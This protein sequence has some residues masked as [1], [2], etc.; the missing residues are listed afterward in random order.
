MREIDD[1]ILQPETSQQDMLGA[2]TL[3]QPMEVNTV[4]STAW[5]HYRAN[6]SRYLPIALRGTGW[7][8]FP[9][10]FLLS[11]LLYMLQQ[12]QV[13]SD[14]SGLTALIVPAW[15]VL[16]LW[17]GA[18][19]LGEFAGISR[20][21]HQSLVFQSLE[22]PEETDSEALSMTL[23]FTHSRRF[24]LLGSAIIKGAILAAINIL[25]LFVLAAAAVMVFIGLGILPGS[26]PNLGL[27]FGGGAVALVSLIV[28]GWLYTW[29]GL[30]L[31]MNEQSLA[32]ETE[33]GMLLSIGQS[34]RL[35]R[36]HLMRSLWIVL[37]ASLMTLPIS[38]VMAVL[39]QVVHPFLF[40]QIGIIVADRKEIST[41]LL[42]YATFYLVSSILGLVGGIIV[43]PF[44]RTVL[45]TLF[46]DIKNQQ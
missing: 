40:Q 46:F 30:K 44:F 1:G 32:I 15:L 17:C 16:F 36:K 24:S 5:Q 14:F 9:A 28:F 22:D 45:T 34:W 27:F 20:L 23:R 25:L 10:V 3:Q 11:A 2:K 38:L 31:L 37:L 29:L 19:S 35:M 13:L 33:S 26:S 4:I 21:V 6:F 39:A 42:P 18:Q 8:L 41:G 43:K 7:L 12:G